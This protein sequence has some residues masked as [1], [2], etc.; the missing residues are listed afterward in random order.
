MAELDREELLS[1]IHKEAVV[2]RSLLTDDAKLDELG[3]AS[4]D[5]ISIIFAIEEKYGV[6]LKEDSFADCTTVGDMIR[7][8]KEK[9]QEQT[10]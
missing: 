5:F 9:V 10:A 3:L 4:L 7:V 2:E 8:L 6:E 1:I